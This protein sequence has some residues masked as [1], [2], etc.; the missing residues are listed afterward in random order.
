M[1]QPV[2]V[3]LY[4]PLQLQFTHLIMVTSQIITSMSQSISHWFHEHDTHVQC[5]SIAVPG[6]RPEFNRALGCCR[7]GDENAND[8]SVTIMWCNHINL[9][10]NLKRNGFQH[11]V[12]SMPWRIE[13]K[14]GS[15]PVLVCCSLK[16][17]A[18]WEEIYFYATLQHWS[19]TI[20]SSSA[21]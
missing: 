18:Q 19:D 7:M 17:N 20:K 5:T 4:I 6:T 13:S 1:P 8:K 12:E 10:Q 3:L 11:L 9:S 2:W 15:Y 14:A 16:K 21:S